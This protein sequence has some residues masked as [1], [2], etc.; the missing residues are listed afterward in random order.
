MGGRRG[1]KT[2]SFVAVGALA[3]VTT[4]AVGVPPAGAQPAWGQATE[5][6]AP[7]GAAASPAAQFAAISCVGAGS[8]TSVGSYVDAS[9]H[10]QAMAG[11]ETSGTWA[12]AVQVTAPTGAGTNPSASLAG[13]WC[14]A[15]GACAAAGSYVDSSGH[16]EDMVATEAA[17]VWAQATEVSLPADAAATAG[18]TTGGIS[19]SSAGNCVVVGGYT[20]SS[21]HD[22]AMEVTESAGVWSQAAKVPSPANAGTDPGASL[23]GVS[24]YSAGSCTAAGSYVDTTSHVR[25]MVA[26]S[27]SGTWGQAAEVTSPAYAYGDIW[28]ASAGSCVTAGSALDGSGNTQA[29][30][31][32]ETLGTWAQPVA[33]PAPSGAAANPHAVFSDV[34]CASLG[35]CL[36]VGSYTTSAGDTEAMVADESGGNWNQAVPVLAPANASANPGAVLHGVSCSSAV[37]C[38]AAG[39]YTTTSSGNE[40]MAATQ[41]PPNPYSP[42]SPTRICDTRPGNP[43]GLSSNAAQ[44][45]G[46]ANAGTTLAAGGTLTID[47]GGL[48]SVPADAS[49]VVLNV[50]VVNPASVGYLTVYPTGQSRPVASNLNFDPHQAV[51]NLVEVGLGPSGQVSIYSSSATDVVVD[52]EGYAA[53]SS[54]LGA[55]AGLYNPL[56]SPARICDTRAGN[57]SG[58]S[59]GPAQCN[60]AGNA[61]STLAAGATLPVQVAGVGG[62]PGSGVSAV[63]LNVTAVGPAGVGYLTVYPAGGSRPTASNVNYVTNQV[64]PNRVVVPVS[65]SGQ[66][67]LYTSTATDVLVDVSGWYS[68]AGGAGTSFVPESAPVRICDTRA[69]NPS[70]LSGPSAQCNGAGDAGTPIPPS[71]VLT[72]TAAGYFG[73]PASAKAVV[74]NV[75]AVEPTALTYLTVYPSGSPPGV[76]DLNPYAGAVEPNLVVATLSNTGTIDIY[77]NSGTVDVVVD[78]LGWYS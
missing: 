61:G 48:F 3:L 70:G 23:G 20:D 68:G 65:G 64:V 34:S 32:A 56:S 11:A 22:Q 30:V 1:G 47:V 42:L 59:A 29:A 4:V 69:G 27:S 21:G 67:D 55:G 74:L 28:C 35:D 33:I 50:T 63:V 6:T 38:A 2:I 24:C 12:Q 75:T 26:T 17:G 39:V 53:P 5:V 77:N 76:S 44:C 57:P 18:A 31:A 15:A 8:C 25:P 62:V 40:A 13:I 78:V 16:A 60:G 41:V 7:S 14:S 49:A 46:T 19:C 71:T 54:S 45:D 58:L 36:A 10:E 51:P 52:L 66:I 9:G 72:I 73:V 37:D 43:S